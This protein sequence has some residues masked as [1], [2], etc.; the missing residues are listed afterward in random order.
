MTVRLITIEAIVVVNFLI[1]ATY[2][3]RV[4]VLELLLAGLLVDILLVACM[5]YVLS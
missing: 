2:G 5:K 3:K 4:S 1:G